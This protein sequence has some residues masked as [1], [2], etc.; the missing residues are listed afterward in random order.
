LA[1]FH[2]KQETPV[3]SARVSRTEEPSGFTT[4]TSRA[5]GAVQ[6]ALGVGGCGREIFVLATCP[7]QFAKAGSAATLPQQEKNNS[8]VVQRGGF[9][10][11][12]DLPS[13]SSSRWPIASRRARHRR[14]MFEPQ[15]RRQRPRHKPS[16]YVHYL[17]RSQFLRMRHKTSAWASGGPAGGRRVAICL[18]RWRALPQRGPPRCRKINDNRF[19]VR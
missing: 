10:P 13:A 8:V 12:G 11:R 17:G 9:I 1:V 7:S 2:G 16:A 15:L 18:V 3:A 4:P 5:V 6:N 14:R 19:R